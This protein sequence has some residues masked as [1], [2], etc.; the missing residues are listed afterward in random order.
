MKYEIVWKLKDGW[1]QKQLGTPLFVGE[2][3]AFE[4]EDDDKDCEKLYPCY[5]HNEKKWLSIFYRSEDDNFF[6]SIISF[7]EGVKWIIERK[8]F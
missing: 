3:A 7:E 8:F 6:E 2:D 1:D 5:Y 4:W